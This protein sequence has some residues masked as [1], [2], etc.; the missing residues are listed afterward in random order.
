MAS[1]QDAFF[2]TRSYMAEM[3]ND[4]LYYLQEGETSD[5]EFAQYRFYRSAIINFCASA[6]AAISKIVHKHLKQNEN[7]L[8]PDDLVLLKNLNDFNEIPPKSFKTIRSKIKTVERLLKQKFTEKTKTSYLELT[9]VRN[10]IIHYSTSYASIVYEDGSV[11]RMANG[12]PE[13]VDAFITE[14]FRLYGCNSGEGFQ[15]KRAPNY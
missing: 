14:L 3:F 7:S 2:S 13:I 5:Y 11:K 4:A 8:K 12:A 6:E 1:E 15:S 9:D 10:K